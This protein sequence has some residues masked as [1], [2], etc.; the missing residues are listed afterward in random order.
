MS[1]FDTYHN[2]VERSRA[3][4]GKGGDPAQA[5]VWA[6]LALAEAILVTEDDGERTVTGT[7]TVDS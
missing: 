6:I 3:Q 7:L 2:M 1:R 4:L 5:Q